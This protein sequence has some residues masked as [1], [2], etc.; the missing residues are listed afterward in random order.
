[1][2]TTV[3]QLFAATSSS[4]RALTSVSSRHAASNNLNCSL[5][6]AG[7][8][9]SVL[10]PTDADVEDD[11]SSA[12]YCD[13]CEKGFTS[14]SAFATHKSSHVSCSFLGCK[15]VGSRRVVTDHFNCYHK[16]HTNQ[17]S[18][19][20][21]SYIEAR[22]KKYPTDANV[23]LPFSSLLGKMTQACMQVL[24]KHQQSKNRLLASD[25]CYDKGPPS[26]KRNTLPDPEEY[27]APSESS[28]YSQCVSSQAPMMPSL[29]S[30]CSYDDSSDSSGCASFQ[31]FPFTSV[32]SNMQYVESKPVDAA[33]QSHTLKTKSTPG[34]HVPSEC[35]KVCP[36][37]F[38]PHQSKVL[39]RTG[40]CNLL[41]KL[42]QEEANADMRTILLCFRAFTSR[43]LV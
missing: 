11:M 29:A 36:T 33:L 7:I 16:N 27:A 10:K 25:M 22:K 4:G 23:R 41:E 30:L 40:R 1:M 28:C 18:Q 21:A 13:A 35:G 3:S 9:G 42:L 39:Y 8:L 24:L 32:L 34:A 20:V 26:K 37:G 15:F 38:P 5:V 2:P 31:K 12:F 17:S 14:H 6:S 19:E 43:G